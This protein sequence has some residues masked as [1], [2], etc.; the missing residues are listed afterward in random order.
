MRDFGWHWHLASAVFLRSTDTGETPV[1]PCNAFLQPTASSS[2]TITPMLKRPSTNRRLRFSLRALFAF[3]TIAGVVLAWGVLRPMSYQRQKSQAAALIHSLGGTIEPCGRSLLGTPGGNWLSGLLNISE[4]TEELWYVRLQGSK[5][6]AKDLERLRGCE[7]IR[8]LDLSD[9]SLGDDAIPSIATLKKLRELRL[10]GTRVTDQ[11]I[12]PLAALS[13]LRLLD[14]RQ[15]AVT[16]DG[17]AKLE[18]ALPDANFQEQ[19][20]LAELPSSQT[21]QIQS[22][23]D[24]ESHDDFDQRDEFGLAG[25]LW[26]TSSVTQQILTQM[27]KGA[28]TLTAAEIEH[29]RRMRGTRSLFCANTVLGAEGLTWIDGF[30]ELRD[31]SVHTCDITARDL[32]VLAKR[33]KL[34]F[35]MISGNGLTNEDL[36]PLTSATRLK[37]LSLNEEH[38]TPHV[39]A[40]LSQIKTL[41]D[42]Q[43]HFW[44]FDE[45]GKKGRATPERLAEVR[46]N[47]AQLKSLPQ[48]KKLKLSGRVLTEETVEPILDIE[49]LQELT[50]PKNV[51][52]PAMRERLR[53]AIPTVI[54][55]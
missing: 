43:L 44:H 47:I 24:F 41:E 1:P 40:T 23:P 2:I 50:I 49:S 25:G 30:D 38:V 32:Q 34:E 16:Y 21:L 31:A 7:W 17:L 37:T 55:Q 3:T 48:L 36:A 29:L 33:P 10:A 12:A 4:L 11:G 46:T 22:M 19:R 26:Q 53:A 54:E 13:R 45:E 15:T 27:G 51:V 20:A 28:R 5:V 52:S 18:Q 39:L 42:L 35:L 9:T 14:T 6:T 8:R